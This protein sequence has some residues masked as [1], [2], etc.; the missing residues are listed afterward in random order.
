MPIAG[1]HLLALMTT[2]EQD[3]ARVR[4]GLL[5]G[6]GAY[7]M[8]G[9]LPLYFRLLDGTQALELVAHRVVWSV[10]FLA[11]V[12][13]GYRL[14]PDLRHALRQPRVV[15]AL[16]LSALLIA[17]NWLTYVW[18]IEQHH[19]LA[20]SLGYFLNPLV[21]VLLGTLVLR[22]TLNRLQIL[23]IALAA[24]GVAILVAGEVQTLWISLTLAVSFALYG[25]VRKLTPVPSSVGLAVETLL[26][27]LP[28]LGVLGW[29][30][31][32]GTLQFGSSAASVVGMIGLGAATSV[33][34]M[35]FARAARSLRMV[36]LGL[37]QYISPS[38]QFLMAVFLFGEQLSGE[39]WLC[40][41]LIWAALVLFV[42]D[43]G[44]GRGRANQ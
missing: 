28:A 11:F 23:A 32:Q 27:G 39:R 4:S 35:L 42:W 8:W 15:A 1:R 18:A 34:L 36:T 7:V 43:S 41:L 14:F 12:L 3:A 9:L 19:V 44:L 40:F 20:A 13:A 2:P 6:F 25:L 29:M 21:N 37:M 26:L 10:V 16:T 17:V 31:S 22:E 30:A 38:L 5:A 33:P 24:V